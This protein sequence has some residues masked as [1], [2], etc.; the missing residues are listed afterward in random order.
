M[1]KEKSVSRWCKSRVCLAGNRVSMSCWIPVFGFRCCHLCKLTVNTFCYVWG[2]K[3]VELTEV[4][5]RDNVALIAN[6]TFVARDPQTQKATQINPLTPQT[7]EEKHL[8]ALGEVHSAEQKKQR[9]LQQQNSSYI[10]GV[11]NERLNKLLAEVYL[12][13]PP[14]CSVLMMTCS[15]CVC[16]H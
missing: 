3:F 2:N 6:F 11:D 10:P 1:I 5:G 12:R 13:Y 4:T 8:Y 7:E 14:F 9:M 15:V 16:F